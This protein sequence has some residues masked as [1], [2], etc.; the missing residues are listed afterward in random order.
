[1]KSGVFSILLAMVAVFWI[2]PRTLRADAKPVPDAQAKVLALRLE[3]AVQNKD[4]AAASALLDLDALAVRVTSGAQAPA[5]FERGYRDQMKRNAADLMGRII[6]ATTSRS[7]YHFLRLRKVDSETRALFRVT[8]G[9]GGVNY[10]DWVIG[11]NASGQ[12]KLVDLYVAFSGELISQTE[13]RIYIS[14]AAHEQPSFFE[15]LTGA[16][17]VYA[18]NVAKMINLGQAMQSGRYDEVLQIYG[19]L[20]KGLQDDKTFM[21]LRVSAAH[22]LRKTR[23]ADYQSAVDDFRRLFPTDPAL[24]LIGLDSLLLAKE[25]SK[26]FQ[27]LDRIEAFTGP[28]A[29]LDYL[30]GN[31]Y[32]KQ[33]G[34]D[35]LARA[36]KLYREA[37]DIEPTLEKSYWGLVGLSLKTKQFDDTAALLNEMESKLHVKFKNLETIPVY[38]EFVKSDAY[39]NWRAAQEQSGTAAR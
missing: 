21:V 30:R 31:I 12:A 33:G 14:A 23:P 26:A 17:K 10:H 38:A 19:T 13:R 7:A 34:T 28:D 9:N 6:K 39:R 5:D 22:R 20:P 32:T 37:I 3:R 15:R 8:N 24:D 27:S 2:A 29:Y 1:M 4:V 16:D 36:K 25:Y 18:A 35:N 11:S